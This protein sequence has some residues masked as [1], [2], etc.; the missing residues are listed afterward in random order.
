MI[1]SRMTDEEI[2]LQFAKDLSIVTTYETDTYHS[3]VNKVAHNK[4]SLLKAVDNNVVVSRRTF[5]SPLNINYTIITFFV[6]HIDRKE[7]IESLNGK[8]PLSNA[9]GMFVYTSYHDCRGRQHTIVLEVNGHTVMD[10]APHAMSRYKQR[11][12]N[13]TLDEGCRT[14]EEHFILNELM[15]MNKEYGYNGAFLTAT[16]IND[17]VDKFAFL[18]EDNVYGLADA[19]DNTLFMNTNN[20]LAVIKQTST[21]PMRYVVLKTYIDDDF[22]NRNKRGIKCLNQFQYEKTCAKIHSQYGI[23]DF[24]HNYKFGK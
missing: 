11:H 10:I 19:D 7:V 24:M 17:M 4:K 15:F 14:F 6:K 5:T 22:I 1:T 8:K 12:P 20:G 21:S 18:K 3:A 13:I 2:A 16:Q 23:S 9:L